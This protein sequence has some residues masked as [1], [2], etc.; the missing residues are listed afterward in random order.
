M[1]EMGSHEG[2]VS[3]GGEHDLIYDSETCPV[4]AVGRRQG[5]RPGRS[6]EDRD[7]G[8]MAGE[9]WLDLYILEAEETRATDVLDTGGQGGVSD[10][11][12]VSGP[13]L[14]EWWGRCLRQEDLER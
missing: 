8:W 1:R 10:A 6:R 7:Q 3:K 11:T 9:K 14:S 4:A 2:C 12:Q 5:Q 13:A